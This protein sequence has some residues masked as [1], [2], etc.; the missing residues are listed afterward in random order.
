MTYRMSRFFVA[1]VCLAVILP[2]LSFALQTDVTAGFAPGSLWLSKTS[3]TAGE[4][5]KIYT[6]V[7]DS[8]DSAI[9]GDVVFYVDTKESDAKHFKLAAGET[10]VLSSSWTALAGTHTFG[11][12]IKNISGVNDTI[13]NSTTNSVSVQ[14]AAAPVSSV[15]QYANIVS[16][17][18]SSSSPAVQNITQTVFGATEGLRRAGS[19]FLSKA[20]SA[21]A[22]T[23]A[24]SSAK[25]PGRT[26]ALA[27]RAPAENSGVL[28]SLWHSI[29]VALLFVFNVQMLF[30]IALLFVLYIVYKIVRA[31]FSEPRPY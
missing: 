27:P 7:Y 26:D 2:N 21:G 28:A 4:T 9:E 29:L 22:T 30:Y 31:L 12:S 16:N 20:L 15:A 5:V 13:S 11:A 10:Q 8:S 1:L 25:R 3:A 17:I 24:S 18:I 14:V 6:V 19:N 23:S